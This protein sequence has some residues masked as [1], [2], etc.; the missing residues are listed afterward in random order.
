MKKWLDKL[1]SSIGMQIIF[2]VIS[3]VIIFSMF[4][5]GIEWVKFYKATKEDIVYDGTIVKEIES[6]TISENKLQLSGWALRVDSTNKK[7]KLALRPIEDSRA[8]LLETICEE[9]EEVSKFFSN[10]WNYGLVRFQTKIDRKKLKENICYEIILVLT[11][12]TILD[13]KKEECTCNVKTGR[14]L[15]NEQL[16]HYNPQEFIQPI[17]QDELLKQVVEEG[18]LCLYDAEETAY[19]YRY[20]ENF[21]WIAGNEFSFDSNNRTH[22]SYHI[23]TS[24]PEKLPEYRQVY[25]FENWDFYFEDREYV[26]E[27]DSEYRVAICAVPQGYPITYFYTAIYNPEKLI[28]IWYSYMYP[29]YNLK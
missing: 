4:F 14:Y 7:I 24:Q 15:Y 23:G 29:A 11:Y 20:K 22:M 17:F 5:A 12:E 27:E 3:N 1:S 13:G 21:Y 9:D 18:E 8:Y 2:F 10:D 25:K 28:P 6:V 19:V 16:Y 26:L